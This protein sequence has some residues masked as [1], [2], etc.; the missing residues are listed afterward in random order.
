MVI[1]TAPSAQPSVPPASEN[2]QGAAEEVNSS[3]PRAMVTA[4]AI[5][6]APG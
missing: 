4:A 1:S 3:L 6:P 5:T 2:N